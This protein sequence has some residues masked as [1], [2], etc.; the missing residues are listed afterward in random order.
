MVD[1]PDYA[2]A[3]SYALSRTLDARGVGGGN[4]LGGSEAFSTQA[5]PTAV[6]VY[7]GSV[8]GSSESARSRASIVNEPLFDPAINRGFVLEDGTPQPVHMR[9]DRARTL[10]A[11]TRE[12]HRAIA[13]AMAGFRRYKCSVQG[14]GQ[15]VQGEDRLYAVNTIATVRDDLMID[16]EGRGMDERMLITDVEFTHSRKEG[17]TASLTLVPLNS[18]VVTP[19]V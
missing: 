18:I 10:E 13:D 12:A 2:Q 1:A 11:A 16:A 5:V 4:I 15:R 6:A 7:T 3:P 9:S 19:E 17:Q 14:F 8:R